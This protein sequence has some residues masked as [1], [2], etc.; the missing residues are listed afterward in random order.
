M[1]WSKKKACCTTVFS[2]L[3]DLLADHNGVVA[4][5]LLGAQLSVVERTLVHV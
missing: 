5:D 2:Y 3:L 4:P 1:Q